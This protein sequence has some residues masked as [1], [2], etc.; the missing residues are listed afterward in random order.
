MKQFQNGSSPRSIAWNLTQ[1]VSLLLVNS[2]SLI[3]VVVQKEILLVGFNSFLQ[4]LRP[5][6]LLLCCVLHSFTNVPVV[7]EI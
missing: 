1:D 4:A 6:F 2:K 7:I 3:E 5:K